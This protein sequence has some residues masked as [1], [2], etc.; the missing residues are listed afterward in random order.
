MQQTCSGAAPC[1][2]ARP[3]S[4]ESSVVGTF[5]R[6]SNL[7]WYYPIHTVPGLFL[8]YRSTNSEASQAKHFTPGAC[9]LLSEGFGILL[10]HLDLRMMPFRKMPIPVPRNTDG[11]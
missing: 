11:Y 7:A 5:Y 3:H 6:R 10:A 4:V 9:I 1:L 8:A 2:H